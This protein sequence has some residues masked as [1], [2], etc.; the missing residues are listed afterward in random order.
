MSAEQRPNRSH[1]DS[2]T[3]T[4]FLIVK[5]LQK[6]YLCTTIS[7][8]AIFTGGYQLSFKKKWRGWQKVSLLCRSFV[9]HKNKKWIKSCDAA[10]NIN[11]SFFII[12]LFSYFQKFYW[13]L[14]FSG[15]PYSKADSKNKT[16]TNMNMKLG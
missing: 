11:M 5:F 6:S 8:Y 7:R 3:C 15:E 10:V 4:T 2:T 13:L 12:V 1:S 16:T 14:L 9:K